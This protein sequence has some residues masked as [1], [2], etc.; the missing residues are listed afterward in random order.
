MKERTIGQINKK[1]ENNEAKIY[2]AEEFK[3]LIKEDNAPSFEEVDVVTAGTCGVMSGTA[4]IFN[5]TVSEPGVFM[6]AK[7]IYLNGVPANIGP[8]P[9]EWLG[10]VD[11]ILHGTSKSVEDSSYGGGFL[12]KDIL[13]G[14]DIRENEAI[15]KHADWA[16]GFLD[17]YDDV[18]K[19]NVMDIIQAEIGKV[20]VKVLED[21][22]VYKCTP[23]GL[24]AFLRFIKTL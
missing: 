24:E 19:D 22:G 13:E 12:L 6:R 10:S 7:N 11:L 8:C 9:N 23:D 17:N 21:A 1:I 4:A 15:E 3:K 2:T 18:N 5:F 16:Y 14:K 20:F